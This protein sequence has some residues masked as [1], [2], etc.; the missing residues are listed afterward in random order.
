MVLV[1]HTLNII[2]KAIIEGI[3]YALREG[4]QGFEKK[5]HH[6][7]KRI[8]ASGG[9]SQSDA[10]CQITADIFGVPTMRVQTYETSSLGAAISGFLAIGEYKTAEEAVANMVKTT[11]VFEP[12][13]ENH[14]KYNYLYKNVYLKMYPQLDTLNKSIVKFER[15]FNKH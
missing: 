4:L 6:K 2:Y 3:G 14:K 11:D 7:I 13:A 1:I 5:L 9:G 8:M 15:K 12:N 10:I